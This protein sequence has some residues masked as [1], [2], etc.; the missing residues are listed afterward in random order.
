MKLAGSA[1]NRLDEA[2]PEPGATLAD[3]KRCAHAARTYAETRTLRRIQGC[4]R[5]ALSHLVASLNMQANPG[6]SVDAIFCTAAPR[7]QS[8]RCVA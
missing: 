4:E 2:A 7:A 8:H 5:V 6:A 1:P 3:S